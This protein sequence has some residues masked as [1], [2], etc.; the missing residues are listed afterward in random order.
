MF[1]SASDVIYIPDRHKSLMERDKETIIA[2]VSL[3]N[4]YDTNTRYYDYVMRLPKKV[5]ISGSCY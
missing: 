2:L 5:P 3:E 4:S 1:M